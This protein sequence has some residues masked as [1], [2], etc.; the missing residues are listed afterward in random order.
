[1]YLT[2]LQAKYTKTIM[3]SSM[4]EFM[5]KNTGKIYNNESNK[6]QQLKAMTK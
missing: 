1:M 4:A 6:V 2:C 5:C 3:N